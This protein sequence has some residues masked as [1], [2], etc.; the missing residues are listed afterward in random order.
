MTTIVEVAQKANVSIS[1]VSRVLNNSSHK[2]NKATREKV[3]RA[4][5][6]LDYRP[7]ALAQSLL[8]KRSMTIGI[9]LPDISNP[10]YAEIVR[11][12]QDKANEKNY[13]VLIQNT[14]LRMDRIERSI[15]DLRE[16]YAD[17]LIFAGGLFHIPKFIPIMKNLASRAVVIGRCGGSFPAV[18]VDNVA[19]AFLA[20]SHLVE[21][22]YREIAF[23]NGVT[24]SSTM[25]DRLKG[26]K[27]AVKYYRCPFC[28]EFVLTGATTPE[29]GYTRTKTLI[30]LKHRPRAIILA[31]DQMAFGAVKAIRNAGL[32]ILQDI[33]LIGF[34]NIPL[35]SYF[36]P[37]IT[38]IEI[39]RYELGGAAM[40]M[41]I[42]LIENGQT[43]Q[44]RWFKVELIKR[45][46]TVLTRDTARRALS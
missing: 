35:C 3:E 38:S 32:K 5:E 37:P 19:A 42:E 15:Y 34:D 36:E 23:I 21:L 39:P 7:N 28:P 29:G 14:D 46:S 20:V 43:E 1:T 33:A 10:Y 18:R 12:I 4:I 44:I 30:A 25:T 6:E 17:G 26:F 13:S 41:L 40:E 8:K 24:G 31:N 11:G 2:V 16:K 22:G 27:K 45:R 9:I